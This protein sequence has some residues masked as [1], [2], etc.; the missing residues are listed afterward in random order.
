MR[1]IRPSVLQHAMLCFARLVRALLGRTAVAD[2][3]LDHGLALCV[4]G[5]DI[6]LSGKGYAFRPAAGKVPKWK[7]LL[8]EARR[9]LKPGDASKLA[10]KLAWGGNLLFRRL[11]RAMGPHGRLPLTAPLALGY[12]SARGDLATGLR[13]R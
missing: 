10:G 9:S 5:V 7:D 1:L 2:D 12:Q 11:G 6:T 4:L 8:V 3:K 13:P